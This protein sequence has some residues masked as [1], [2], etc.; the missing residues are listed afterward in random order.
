[1]RE[2]YGAQL[3][4]E[5][6]RTYQGLMG[7]V[8]LERQK[9]VCRSRRRHSHSIWPEPW[10]WRLEFTT[11]LSRYG[12]PPSTG[13]VVR[14]AAALYLAQ[15][16]KS[17]EGPGSVPG[18]CPLGPTGSPLRDVDGVQPRAQRG[19]V[20]LAEL[21]AEAGVDQVHQAALVQAV[22]AAH[23]QHPLHILEEGPGPWGGAKEAGLVQPE[24][25]VS[26]TPP[27]GQPGGFQIER[28]LVE[29]SPSLGDLPGEMLS[30]VCIGLKVIFTQGNAFP[31]QIVPEVQPPFFT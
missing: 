14:M 28:G 27:F 16:G 10:P 3:R 13:S 6:G 12:V 20:V 31:R 8:T 23:S 25:E 19:Q 22:Q 21:L 24:R 4:A 15:R 5:R 30:V 2:G 29:Q 26:S 1:M 11:N 17:G 7:L 9:S 18:L